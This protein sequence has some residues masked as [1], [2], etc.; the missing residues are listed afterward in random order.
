MVI[1]YGVTTLV[2]IVLLV[3]WLVVDLPDVHVAQLT[4]ASI[5]VV[6]IFPLIWYP[7]S[8]TLWAAADYLV[9]RTTPEYAIDRAEG[10]GRR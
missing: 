5:V 10:D 6:A 2:W 3:V 4:I 9:F 7:F 8:K 1:N